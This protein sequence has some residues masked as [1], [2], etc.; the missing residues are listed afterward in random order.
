MALGLTYHRRSF[1]D[2]KPFFLWQLLSDGLLEEKNE[3]ALC[4]LFGVVGW[5]GEERVVCFTANDFDF[6]IS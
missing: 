2:A 1:L 6:V 3:K 5:G 4:W